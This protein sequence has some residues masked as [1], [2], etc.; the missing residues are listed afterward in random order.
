MHGPGFWT[1]RLPKTGE[2]FAWGTWYQDTEAYGARCCDL[3]AATISSW[4]LGP[5]WRCCWVS[6]CQWLTPLL[7]PLATLYIQKLVLVLMILL[8]FCGL[9][10]VDHVFELDAKFDT[11]CWR[12]V[13][14][15]VRP[16]TNRNRNLH[17]SKINFQ[18]QFFYHQWQSHCCLIYT[19][20]RILCFYIEKVWWC[21][22]D[23]CFAYCVALVIDIFV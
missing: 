4:G 11:N 6:I 23:I 8:M 17:L 2:C 22:A 21:N 15:I 3:T 18:F 19:L 20:Y 9:S 7:K 16:G 13:D 10:R 1:L 14:G 5:H 12:I